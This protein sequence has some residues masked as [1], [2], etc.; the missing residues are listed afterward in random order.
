MQ[1]KA[2][3]IARR[4]GTGM[5]G[6]S[7]GQK[8]V[9][10]LAALVLVLGGAAFWRWA[11]APV[12]APL[13]TGLAA[14]DAAAIVDKLD[15]SGTKYELTDGGNTILVPKDAVYATR[16]AMSADG[17]PAAAESGYSLLDQQGLTSS[18]FQQQVTYQRALEGELAK[19]VSAIEGVSSATVH[20]AVPK[21]DV[22]LSEKGETTASVMVQTRAG[23]ELTPRQVEAV[24]HLVSSSI[25]GLDPKK[26]TVVDGTGALLSAQGGGASGAARDQT[27]TD[28]ENRVQRSVQAM[29]DRVLGTGAAVA[30]VTA[31]LDL[32]ST[33]T[34]TEKFI[35]DETVR[36]LS[37]QSTKETYTGT[38]AGAG[39][40]LGP[41]NVQG[42]AGAGADGSSYTK[43]STTVGNPVGKVTERRVA[44]P[45]KVRKQSVA[46]VVDS[47][48]TNRIDEAAMSELVSTAAGVDKA[49]GDTVTV[50]SM[51]FDDTA[52]KQAEESAKA[53]KS[54]EAAEAKGDLMKTAILAGAVLL[55]LLISAIGALK[56]K[57]AAKKAGPAQQWDATEVAELEQLRAIALQSQAAIDAASG[58]RRALAVGPAGAGGADADQRREVEA[59]VERQPEEMAELLRGWLADRRS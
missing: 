19:T 48:R 13:F 10:V 3:T 41:D 14:S 11:S 23:A 57:K 9:A 40:V 26:V 25:E 12:Y 16:L 59:L 35:D 45:G 38:A 1:A 32:D 15:A 20:L 31:D 30:T 36:P 29:L 50:Q 54:A 49:R 4:A 34:T 17:L 6:F 2:L 51:V 39:G 52:L 28:Y 53:A 27:T 5:A 44:T 7:A 21:D 37:Q 24:V 18:Q 58:D 33:D 47:Q 43:E 8:V 42:A 55:L 46:V 22:F 56:R